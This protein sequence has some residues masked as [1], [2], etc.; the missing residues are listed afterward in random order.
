MHREQRRN[1]KGRSCGTGVGE[2]KR[3]QERG[4]GARGQERITKAKTGKTVVRGARVLLDAHKHRPHLLILTGTGSG[5]SLYLL[6]S[7]LDGV[8]GCWPPGCSFPSMSTSLAKYHC[9]ERMNLVAETESTTNAT[10][11]KC[12]RATACGLA[13][14]EGFVLRRKNASQWLPNGPQGTTRVTKLLPAQAGL[15]P[16]CTCNMF[17]AA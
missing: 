14:N 8:S 16:C 6:N 4:P 13:A 2:Q 11:Q 3:E 15:R 17:C 1:W 10:T 12:R 9:V 5:D 7:L